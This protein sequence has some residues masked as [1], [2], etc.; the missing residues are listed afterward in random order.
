[1]S[2]NARLTASAVALSVGLG[3]C[4]LSQARAQEDEAPID[5]ATLDSGFDT[6]EDEVE[7]TSEPEQGLDE[8]VV[9]ARRRAEPLQQTPIAVSAVGAQEIQERG[10]DNI[11]KVDQVAPNVT[12]NTTAA[13]SGSSN[14]AV[15]FI[16]GVGQ[17]DFYPQIDPGVG[18]YLDGVYISRTT[19]AILDTIDLEQIEVL[20]GPQG[21]LYGKNTIG[22][23]INITTR[24]P[25]DEFGGYVDVTTGAFERLDVKARVDIPLSDSLRTSLT[26]ANLNRDGYI[27]L[28]DFETGLSTGVALG[29]VDS[30]SAAFKAEWEPDAP[31]TAALSVDWTEKR[32]DSSGSTLLAVADGTS[33]A[34]G[35]SAFIQNTFI[36][37][38]T[39]EP[40]FTDQFITG[41]PFLSFGQPE[42]SRSNLDLFGA[43][44]TATWEATDW[45]DVKSIT[46]YRRADSENDRDG[47]NSP[48][49][50]LHPATRI[51][52]EQFSQEIQFSGEAVEGRLNWLVGGFY[53]TEDIFFD[54]PVDIAF[55]Q[56]EN[57]SDVKN[58]SLAFFG[59]A[60]YDVT[61]RLGVTGGIRWT[62]D[63]KSNDP[64]IV[65]TGGFTPFAG[66][67]TGMPGDPGFPF[68]PAEGPFAPL[69][70]PDEPDEETFEEV[71]PSFSVDYEVT[72]DLFVYASYAQGFKSG[73]FS[74]RIAFPRETTPSFDPETV[75]TYEAGF[76]L[77]ALS[78]RVRINAAGF[79]SEYDD[80][81]VVVF[82]MIEPI[83]ENA[84]SAEISGFEV[85]LTAA[86]TDA[87]DL[88]AAVGYLD[89]E[90]TAI[91]PGTLI[92]DGADLAYTPEWTINGSAAYLVPVQ[93]ISGDV[94]VRADWSYR[95]EVFFDA[96]NTPELRQDG[97]HLLNLSATYT[98][99]DELWSV[100]VGATNVTDEEYIVGG[101]A[102]LGN[103]S[104]IDATF[105]RPREWYVRARRNF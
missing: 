61:N 91:D 80:L 43:A 34:D 42:R 4:L 88:S 98:D 26:Y 104:F 33:P 28:V 31:F 58:D 73:G 85:E 22:G 93:A 53:L 99:L 14:A 55:I 16:R 64:R 65:P 90:Y 47:D 78:N 89:A 6:L 29:N 41:D 62:R 13:N 24:G 96:L 63:E 5:P 15:V 9:T 54:G 75:T 69:L 21:T 50:I 72:D 37:P 45:L 8:I 71:T 23:A 101:F 35:T 76:K 18:I 40:L 81:Q 82:N 60:T 51:D 11:S 2:I 66:P 48:V 105:A 70:D 46:A 57:T 12:F 92:P 95:S 1:M 7:E 67:P 83:N 3:V 86:P 30:E 94:R 97:Y 19:G 17:S 87:L 56:I 102:D 103:T 39:G 27:R 10:F 25:A 44:L 77:D 59:Q 36:A 49:L 100:S 20:R 52:Q 32:E 74:Q 84:G 79:Y 68:A 38:V